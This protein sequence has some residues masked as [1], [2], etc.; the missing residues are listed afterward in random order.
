MKIVIEN[1]SKKYK[2]DVWGLQDFNLE[3]KSGILGLLGP[4]GAGKTTLM[5][6]L[7][8]VTKPTSGRVIWNDED[9]SKSPDGL[10]KVLGYL[11]QDFVSIPI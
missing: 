5:N 7:A 11:P 4:N 3:L 2:G 9:I 10:R 6:I 1:V 8:T